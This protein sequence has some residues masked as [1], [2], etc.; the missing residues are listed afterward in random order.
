MEKKTN[1][2]K[3]ITDIRRNDGVYCNTKN[4]GELPLRIFSS[5]NQGRQYLQPRMHSS[6]KRAVWVSSHQK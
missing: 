3:E 4:I 6:S 5:L 2:S 1:K